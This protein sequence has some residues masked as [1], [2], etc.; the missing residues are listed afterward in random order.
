MAWYMQLRDKSVGS[1]SIQPQ[2]RADCGHT[3]T[4]SRLQTVQARCK[5]VTAQVIPGSHV[6]TPHKGLKQGCLE[7]ITKTINGDQLRD[8]AA[9]IKH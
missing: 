6:E 8:A 9:N 7:P 3:H 5:P 2:H 1:R 4:D